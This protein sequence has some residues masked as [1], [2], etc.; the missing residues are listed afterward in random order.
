MGRQFL[1]GSCREADDFDEESL[2]DGVFTA[3]HGVNG[4]EGLC[5]EVSFATFLADV[6]LD[7]FDDVELAVKPVVHGDVLL[8]GLVVAEVAAHVS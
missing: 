7:V 6:G 3:E 2:F 5:V 8:G 1:F 4:V